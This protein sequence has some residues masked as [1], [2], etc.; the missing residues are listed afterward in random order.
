[1]FKAVRVQLTSTTPPTTPQK[2]RGKVWIW[3]SDDAARIP[4]QMRAR[5]FWGTITLRLQRIERTQPS[6]PAK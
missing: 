2:E 1:T 6:A 3:Y 4:V 5:M